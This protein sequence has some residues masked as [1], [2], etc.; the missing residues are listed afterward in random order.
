MVKDVEGVQT[1]EEVFDGVA[2]VS[3]DEGSENAAIVKLRE[4]DVELVECTAKE[5]VAVSEL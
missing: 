2:F 3:A 1:S 5:Y 4:D